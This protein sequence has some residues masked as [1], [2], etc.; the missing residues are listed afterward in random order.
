MFRL[1]PGCFN[2]MVRCIKPALLDARGLALGLILFGI[3]SPLVQARDRYASPTEA[4]PG[5]MYTNC[6]VAD[7]PWSIHVVQME[8]SNSLY[9]IRSFHAGGIALGLD[10]LSDQLS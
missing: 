7:M 3:A 5:I 9:E 8:L 6:R 10:T 4:L 1:V 2:R